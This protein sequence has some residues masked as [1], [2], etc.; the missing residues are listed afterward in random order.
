VKLVI[1][2]NGR[3]KILNEQEWWGLS[4]VDTDS[5]LIAR[6]W[7]ITRVLQL[8]KPAEPQGKSAVKR[9]VVNEQGN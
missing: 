4:G 2:N 3:E 6:G 8:F 5:K 9:V 7:V 1:A